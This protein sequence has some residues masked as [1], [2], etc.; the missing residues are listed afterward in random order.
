MSIGPNQ[1]LYLNNLND[2]MHKEE[3]RRSLYLLFSQFGGILDV[4]ALKTPAMRGQSFVVFK[5]ITS[6]T[7]AM[8][9]LQSFMFF[10]KPMKIAY[11]KSKSIAAMKEDGTFTKFLA[12]KRRAGITTVNGGDEDGDHS[13]DDEPD[14]KVAHLA[15]R[16][17]E[18]GI[19]NTLY[20]S[21][22]P[23]SDKAS[24][25]SLFGRFDG[26]VDVRTV[27]GRPD[28]CFVEYQTQTQADTAQKNL[29]EFDM[30]EGKLIKV[31]FAA[32]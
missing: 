10:G 25:Q 18:N 28:M 21:N 26:L 4:V 3:L 11:A 9:A 19:R 22:L 24:L 17:N 8:R 15:E 12:K 30:G 32:E 27:A 14:T 29:D 31:V 16:T 5:D 7:T 23:N 6:A 2:K 20:V 1:T 13:D